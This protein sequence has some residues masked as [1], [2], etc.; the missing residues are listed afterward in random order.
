MKI[1]AVSFFV[2]ILVFSCNNTAKESASDI[3]NNAILEAGGAAFESSKIKFDF[4]DKSYQATRNGGLFKLE[5]TYI[6]EG[7]TIHNELSNATFTQSVNSKERV[8]NDSL[9]SI[10]ENALNSV[11]YFSVLPYGLNAAAVNKTDLGDVEINGEIYQ[12]I[13]VTFNQEG[14]GEDF[15]DVFLYWFH[16]E[17]KTMDYLAYKYHTNGGGI[18]FREAKNVRRINNLLFADYNNYKPKTK[19]IN[20]DTIDSLFNSGKLELL[21]EINLENIKVEIQ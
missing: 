10:Y 21:S 12:K 9:V 15:D 8:L 18:R 14:G 5:Q 13:K 11:H 2:C 1:L 17:R 7:D 20:F 6:L 16:K 3:V 4:R 19:D